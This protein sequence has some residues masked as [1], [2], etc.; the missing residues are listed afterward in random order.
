MIHTLVT[1]RETNGLFSSFEDF[2]FRMHSS[3]MN[4]RTLENL[5]RAGAFDSMGC[6]RKA[7]L[8]VLPLILDSLSRSAKNNI[9]GQFDLFGSVSEETSSLSVPIPDIPDYSLRE[10]MVMEKEITGLYLS[11]HPMDEYRDRIRGIGAVPIGSI[12]SDLSAEGTHRFSDGQ[13]VV[14]AGVVSS[15]RTRAT[16]NNSLMCYVQFEDETGNMEL[17]VFQR[18]LDVS[19]PAISSNAVLVVSGRI[20]LRDEKEP[21]LTVEEITPID[22]LP[23]AQ[24]ET[25]RSAGQAVPAEPASPPKDKVLYVRLPSSEDPML[26]RIELLLTMFPGSGKMVIW[27]EKENRRIGAKCLLHQALVA[28]LTELLGDRNVVLK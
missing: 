24:E 7:I 23:A 17:V 10:K 16:R 3:E 4:R 15:S 12:L 8:E 1:E 25:A 28:E 21:Q 6:N 9:D 27:C 20:T 22:V 2:C 26:R 11:G 14:I 18:V 13:R 19:G 5:V